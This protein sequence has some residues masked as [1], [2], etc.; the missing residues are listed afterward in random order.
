MDYNMFWSSSLPLSIFGQNDNCFSA[1][2]VLSELK[3]ME[4][5]VY[6]FLVDFE[7]HWKPSKQYD[8]SDFGK[9]KVGCYY[10]V[11]IAEPDTIVILSISNC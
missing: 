4:H 8:Y 2:V 11:L 7:S 5:S 9:L 1:I 10:V 3:W 6:L